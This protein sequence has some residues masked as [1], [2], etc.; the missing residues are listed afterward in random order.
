MKDDLRIDLQAIAGDE[1]QVSAFAADL[2]GRSGPD[3][4]ARWTEEYAASGAMKTTVA[5]A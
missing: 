3:L 1:S 4:Q 5:M 2:E